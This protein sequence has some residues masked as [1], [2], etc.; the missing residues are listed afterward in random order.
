MLYLIDH[1]TFLLFHIKSFFFFRFSTPSPV[2]PRTT[3]RLFLVCTALQNKM[4]AGEQRALCCCWL[5]CWTGKWCW[6]SV[7]AS[8]VSW[9]RRRR[10]NGPERAVENRFS[11][12]FPPRGEHPTPR[13]QSPPRY[14][15]VTPSSGLCYKMG[16]ELVS[17][18][19]LVSSALILC[20]TRDTIVDSGIREF[21]TTE[22][23]DRRRLPW[24]RTSEVHNCNKTCWTKGGGKCPFISLD[25][26]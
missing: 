20:G 8:D 17:L 11:Y 18:V 9:W 15:G 4:A 24:C 1:F 7:I 10:C 5:P 16:E 22:Q 13:V 2:P 12:R 14:P 19:W 21:Q 25:G 6:E 23:L 26:S 3:P